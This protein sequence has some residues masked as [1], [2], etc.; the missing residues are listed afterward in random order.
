ME[1][2]SPSKKSYWVVLNGVENLLLEK[3]VEN[4]E[5]ISY[6]MALFFFVIPVNLQGEGCLLSA[7]VLPHNKI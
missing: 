5:S 6:Y 3:E 1:V 7:Y 2:T 4:M